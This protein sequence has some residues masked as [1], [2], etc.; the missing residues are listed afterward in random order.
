MS[1]V[2]LRFVD[3]CFVVGLD[4]ELMLISAAAAAAAAV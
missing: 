3:D 2:G 1:W 4:W